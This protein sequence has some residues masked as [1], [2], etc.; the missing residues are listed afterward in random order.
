MIADMYCLERRLHLDDSQPTML[1]PVDA[2]QVVRLGNALR[3][4]MIEN[5][6]ARR[7][8]RV[9][10]WPQIG[11]DSQ[12]DSPA[13][14]LR[15]W[16]RQ[17]LDAC[18]HHGSTADEIPGALVEVLQCWVLARSSNTSDIALAV[19]SNAARWPPQ[20]NPEREGFPCQRQTS[21]GLRSK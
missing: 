4:R 14:Q 17:Y 1:S 10:E 3:I 2:I 8:D 6:K 18:R 11:K 12:L 9:S 13:T 16:V 20:P 21:E 5:W 15:D 7:D 19:P